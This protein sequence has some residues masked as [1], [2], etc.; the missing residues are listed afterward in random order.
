MVLVGVGG[1]GMY[2]V[3]MMYGKYF[4]HLELYAR[5]YEK[6]HHLALLDRSLA[7]VQVSQDNKLCLQ[8]L[9]PEPPSW[10]PGA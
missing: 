5:I 6:V 2:Y 8:F 3:Y 7:G 4:L 9:H 10:L 1:V